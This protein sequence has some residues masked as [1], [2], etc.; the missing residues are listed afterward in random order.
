MSRSPATDRSALGDDPLTDGTA[1]DT[2]G[3][4]VPTP[5]TGGE[6]SDALIE[7]QAVVDP[8]ADC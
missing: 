5:R 7:P 6:E 1:T 2:N 3:E 8:D 4:G